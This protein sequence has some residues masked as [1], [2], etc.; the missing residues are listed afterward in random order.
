MKE[1][2]STNV[3]MKKMFFSFNNYVSIIKVEVHTT[4]NNFEYVLHI[5]TTNKN[6]I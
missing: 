1:N 4:I 2:Y 6:E 5:G 3:L